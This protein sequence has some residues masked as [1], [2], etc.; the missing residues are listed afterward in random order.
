MATAK[1]RWVKITGWPYEVS[2]SGLV[3]SLRTGRVLIPMRTG[4]KRKQ[5]S[6]VR[7]CRNGE[8]KD[9]KV[10]HLVLEAFVGLRPKG[11][12]MRHLND[13]QFDDRLANLKWGTWSANALDRRRNKPIKLSIEHATEIL[14]RR[15][16]GEKGRLLAIEF[17]VSEQTVCDIYKS[18]IHTG[19][20]TK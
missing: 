19:E 1:I 7:L 15:K 11:Q 6:T 17:G 4:H 8:Y 2:D 3:R 16:A 20:L 12:A 5:Y 9:F 18:R 14:Q 13:H 10:G